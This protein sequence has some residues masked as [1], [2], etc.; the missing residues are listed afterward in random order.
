MIKKI[1]VNCLFDNLVIFSVIMPNPQGSVAIGIDGEPFLI[2][3]ETSAQHQ[4]HF[5]GSQV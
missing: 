4:Q 5:V 3:G 2:N 1:K